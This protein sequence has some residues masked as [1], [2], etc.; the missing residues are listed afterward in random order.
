MEFQKV[1]VAPQIVIY[2]NIFKNSKGLIDVLENDNI[3]SSFSNWERWY[4]QGYRKHSTF[5]ILN[6]QANQE[7]KYLLEIS[8]IINFINEDY[9]DEF[10]KNNGIWP[11]FIKDWNIVKD[12]KKQFD[13][14]YFKYDI[15]KIGKRPQDKLMMEYHVDDFLL[16]NT[17]QSMRHVITINFY[18]NNEYF[19][20]EICAYDAVSGK[21]YM[22]KPSPGDAVVMPST[23]PFY[24]A[25]K[26][27]QDFDRYF[28]RVFIDY[29]VPGNLNLN[30]F[31]K[32][33]LEYVNQDLQ[34]I[35][36]SFAEEIV[37]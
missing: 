6:H 17:V 22:Y 25:V 33:Y 19:G 23:E 32:K 11:S 15:K 12:N 37:D 3:D 30:E 8:N 2:K 7:N 24:H 16:E 18:L 1:I 34:M 28:L 36:T 35:I 14:D 20:G 4:E 26:P 27:F 5:N 9:F 13:I 29:P 10:G 31:N 21:S